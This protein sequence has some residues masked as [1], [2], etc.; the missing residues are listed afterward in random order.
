MP[1]RDID[2]D[3]GET[4]GEASRYTAHLDRGWSLLDRGDLQQAR[5]SGHQ[6]RQLRPEVPDAAMLMAAISLAESD[7]ESSLEWYERAIEADAEYVDAQ[8]AAAQLLLYDLDDPQRALARAEQARELDEATIADRLDLGLLEIE[9]L[10][11]LADRGAA[12]SRI[13][14][15]S[16][17]DT[18]EA[19]LDPEVQGPDLD[20]TMQRFAGSLDELDGEEVEFLTARV[21]GLAVRLARAH[22]DLANPAD[23]RRWVDSLLGRFGDDADLWYLRNEAAY[24]AGDAVQAAHAALQVLQLDAAAPPV[25]W[26]PDPSTLHQ[27]V[28]DLLLDCADPQLRALAREPG[29]VV[30]V[31]EAP[32]F[33]LVLEGVDPRARALA[34]ATRGTGDPPIVLTGMALYR[35][36]LVRLA[37]EAGNLDAELQFAIFDE[38]AAFFAFDDVRRAALGLPAA[39]HTQHPADPRRADGSRGRAANEAE[40]PADGGRG[41]KLGSKRKASAK[42]ASEASAKQA[43][44]DKTKV[45]KTKAKKTSAEKTKAKKPATKTKPAAKT[46]PVAKKKAAAATKARTRKKAAAK[47]PAAKKPAAKKPATKTKPRAKKPAV[48]K[49]AAK[50]KPAKKPLA[51]KSAT[52]TAT[53]RTTAKKA[54]AKKKS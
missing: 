39:E 5:T 32:A 22:L 38:L 50:R 9:A 6:A 12:N 40:G 45:E 41:R 8:L 36:N 15:L 28:V 23:A 20:R 11:A 7:P 19:I 18:L 26:S 51:K 53:K 33:E 31:N 44:A 35:R 25:P 49:P 47:K 43:T 16:E 30:V 13:Q 21:V 27:R 14:G 4:F 2:Y 48:K 37:L 54:A 1:R 46:K 34:L 10:L 3:G 29:F 17:L 52:K 42:Q 24:I